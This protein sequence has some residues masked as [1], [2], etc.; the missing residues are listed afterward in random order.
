MDGLLDLLFAFVRASSATLV[1]ELVVLSLILL[2]NALRV[3]KRI[4]FLLLWVVLLRMLMPV[5]L[6]SQ[7]SLFNLP[8]VQEFSDR[9]DIPDH[10]GYVGEFEVA[11]DGTDAYDEA[12]YSGL[13]PVDDDSLHFQYLYYTEDDQGDLHPPETYREKYGTLTVCIWLGGVALFWGYGILSAI[14]LK[15]RVS[16]ATIV[17]PGVYE[18][19]R[20][21]AP[22]I[23]G[24]FKPV[25]YL[26]LGLDEAQKRMI[27]CHERMHLR[28]GDHLFKI[29]AY[30]A[31]GLHWFNI[32]IGIY[33]Y[34]ALLE[35]MEEAC[36]QDVLT[37]LGDQYK[38]DYSQT[39]LNFSSKRQFGR[40]MTVA[41]S[42]SW[43]KERIQ[44]VLKYKKP[45]RWLTVPALGLMLAA[46]VTLTTSGIAQEG[47]VLTSRFLTHEEWLEAGMPGSFVCYD[48][49]RREE[50]A[51]LGFD[52]EV[53]DSDGLREKQ[54]I[55][56]VMAL[57][58][59][60]TLQN[61]PIEWYFDLE[62]EKALHQYRSLDVQLKVKDETVKHT[63]DLQGFYDSMLTCVLGHGEPYTIS[64][65]QSA[66]LF[67]GLFQERDDPTQKDCAQ[68]SEQQTVPLAE[69]QLAVVLRM[70]EFNTA[71]PRTTRLYD[72]L[73]EDFFLENN[74]DIAVNGRQMH[75]QGDTFDALRSKLSK[76]A[77]SYQISLGKTTVSDEGLPVVRLYAKDGRTLELTFGL[78]AVTL[79][80]P[81]TGNVSQ[82]RGNSFACRAVMAE[83]YDLFGIKVTS[84]EVFAMPQVLGES[85]F[86]WTLYAAIPSKDI[87]LYSDELRN[88]SMLLMDGNNYP[89]ALHYGDHIRSMAS[90]DLNGDGAEELLIFT[91]N[92]K[93]DRMYVLSR[94]SKTDWYIDILDENSLYQQLEPV[95]GTHADHP[96]LFA[97]HLFSVGTERLFNKTEVMSAYSDWHIDENEP[98]IFRN[99]SF[100]CENGKMFVSFECLL[101]LQKE[102]KERIAPLQTTLVPC[103]AIS[104]EIS[105]TGPSIQNDKMPFG[106]SNLSIHPLDNQ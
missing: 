91:G 103:A 52:L 69:G 13:L 53:W 76:M 104:C 49:E 24:I 88:D 8:L 70:Q 33:F 31:V 5:G 18:T 102:P 89:I 99:T 9:Y 58:P 90:V 4:S 73:P 12:L 64:P 57:E 43:I 84:Q 94:I 100:S 7:F 97:L 1:V 50:T 30:L 98:Y 22:F 71:Q 3:R 92:N 65:S 48:L 95:Y 80:D 54:R 83:I 59:D 35:L 16:T 78:H 14:L 32:W 28:W 77:F 25:I 21:D 20:I 101:Q 67:C 60:L 55:L 26:P 6:P 63:V 82:V 45:F 85:A 40:V 29:I 34:R 79:Y 62:S 36:D 23:L 39:L 10:G 75:L 17:E 87:W 66:V 105:F 74:A 61:I 106:F 81:A 15:R 38:T 11:V 51:W 47:S 46:A 41:F 2:F 96:E 56:D 27:L 42:E 86:G 68:L 44:T 93:N 72:L 37:E 19:D